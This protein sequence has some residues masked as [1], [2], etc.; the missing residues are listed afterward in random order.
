MRYDA[1]FA[2]RGRVRHAVR[3][4]ALR[5]SSPRQPVSRRANIRLAP[6]NPERDPHARSSTR[7][8]ARARIV[9]R[10]DERCVPA[11]AR[12]PLRRPRV[13]RDGRLPESS[14][15][16]SEYSSLATLTSRLQSS[17]LALL[18]LLAHRPYAREHGGE[19]G[20]SHQRRSRR[21][22]RGE[23]PREAHTHDQRTRRAARHE[24]ANV[25]RRSDDDERE[26]D[27]PEEARVAAPARV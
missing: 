12:R 9:A 17:S 26:R 7:D 25:L 2:P 23:R 10:R 21:R 19:R 20:R 11:R 15:A 24:S 18:A 5:R 22:E 27:A 13:A 6:Q 3:C 4:R 8:T 1:A 14:S 16:S